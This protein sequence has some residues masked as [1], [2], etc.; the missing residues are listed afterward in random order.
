MEQQDLQ[1]VGARVILRDPSVQDV[2][3][4]DYWLQPDHRWQELDGPNTDLP[5]PER[6]QQLL[7][8]WQTHATA[9]SHSVPRTL[10]S[11]V[12][13]DDG[14]MLGQVTWQADPGDEAATRGLSIVIYNPDF[15][16]YGLGYEALGLWIDYLFGA[17][18]TLTRLELRT[19]NS[20]QGMVRLAQKLGFEE[21]TPMRRRRGL[22]FLVRKP[23]SIGYSLARP[24]WQRR[25]GGGFSATLVGH[26]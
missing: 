24:S 9:S 10:L 23:E 20:N 19:W 26:E 1:I 15:W 13:R 2:A 12:A 7:D 6:R 14:Q 11:I 4:L 22:R 8:T 25:F 18:A 16:G 17:D 21:V 3:V 5:S